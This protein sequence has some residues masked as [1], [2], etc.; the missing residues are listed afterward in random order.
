MTKLYLIRHAEA[1]GNVYRRIHGQY[2]S[3]LTDNGYRQVDAL[4]QRFG[5]IPLTAVYASDLFRATK[6][7]QAIAQSK[8]LPLTRRADLREVA[9]GIW[10]DRAW[11]EVDLHDHETMKLF[12]TSSPQWSVQG[13]E[14]FEILRDRAAKAIYEIAKAH[15]D[16]SVAVVAHGMAIRYACGAFLGLSVEESSKLGHSDNTGVTL[17]EIDGDSVQIAFRDDSSH[18]SDEIST[19]R[20]QGWWK[21]K[22]GSNPDHN[23]WYQPMDLSQMSYR[24]LYLASR[25]EAWLDLG[26]DFRYLE[27]QNYME[28]AVESYRAGR[29]YLLC[30]QK[31]HTI[32]GMLQMNPHRYQEEGA[33]FISFFY[34]IPENRGN[35]LGVQMLGQ[36]VSTFRP[37]GR[38]RLRLYCGEDNAPAKRFYE[39][40]GFK[41]IDARRE[42]FGNVYLMEKYIGYEDAGRQS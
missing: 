4:V 39:R 41:A 13:G 38:D 19:L 34:M 7:A 30:A 5:E 14:T 22:D 16:Q 42:P 26:R 36:A 28:G 21:K 11:G 6:T 29:Q 9:M 3:I 24:G 37:M 33:G 20:K 35:G 40:Y 23:L 2:D 17:L 15:P 31:R 10:E 8:G 25:Q 32:V 18:L 1:E 12:A 27:N